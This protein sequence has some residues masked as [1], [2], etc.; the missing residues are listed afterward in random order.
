MAGGGG[1]G[2]Y[3]A[4][5]AD[6]ESRGQPPS[7]VPTPLRGK[8]QTVTPSL[9]PEEKDNFRSEWGGDSC[10]ASHYP[11]PNKLQLDSHLRNC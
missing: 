3:R 4:I 5:R 2:C 6:W 1:G 10:K 7:A 8:N 9:L 11:P